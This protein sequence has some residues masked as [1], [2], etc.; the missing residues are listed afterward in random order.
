MIM[1]VCVF[2]VC[3]KEKRLDLASSDLNI[4][5]LS[6]EK[7]N[8]AKA[9]EASSLILLLNTCKYIPSVFITT[10]ILPSEHCSP[11]RSAGP[12]RRGFGAKDEEPLKL[13]CFCNGAVIPQRCCFRTNSS[14][15]GERDDKSV[16]GGKGKGEEGE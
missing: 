6:V 7:L 13:V 10:K 12:D 8:S 15:N 11:T 2:S 16:M 5:I 3:K 4:G 1:C 14:S 9:E